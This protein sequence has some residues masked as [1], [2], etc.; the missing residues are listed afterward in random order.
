M[1]NNVLP[2]FQEFLKSRSLVAEK[3]ISFYAYWVSRFLYFSNLNQDMPINLRIEKFI[4]SLRF[5]S[6]V[7]DWQ[8][9]QARVAIKIYVNQ[10][11]GAASVLSDSEKKSPLV[12]T[13]TKKNSN[14]IKNIVVKLREAI[15]VKHY[16]YST[17]RSYIDWVKR[18]Y[19]YL[20]DIKKKEVI[21]YGLT[22]EDVRDYLTYLAIKR[23]VASS[24]QNQAFNALLFL[25]REILKMALE[26]A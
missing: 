23:R 9:N 26:C 18:F 2:E 19:E 5:N 10:F 3:S 8:A 1:T 24:T 16:S 13:E 21:D 17:E 12:M 14:T 4:E 7:T 22:G 6:E 25:F 15:R 20:F 11:L